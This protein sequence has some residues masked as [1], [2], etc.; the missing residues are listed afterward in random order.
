MI[1]VQDNLAQIYFVGISSY[2][3]NVL[4]FVYVVLK[5]KAK[6]G[7]NL[8][9]CTKEK[10]KEKKTILSWGASLVSL[11]VI[12]LDSYLK[13]QYVGGFRLKSWIYRYI[14]VDFGFYL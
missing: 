4:F 11:L 5:A 1:V 10:F 3:N 6:N 7:N 9:K 2:N 8:K 13:L 12:L 14:W